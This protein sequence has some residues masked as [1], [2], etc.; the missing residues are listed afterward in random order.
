MIEMSA[1]NRDIGDRKVIFE[2][3]YYFLADIGWGIRYLHQRPP[4][5]PDYK[6]LGRRFGPSI[7]LIEATMLQQNSRIP[8]FQNFRI[9]EFQ[10]FRIPEFQNFRISE[11]R[12]PDAGLANR[13]HWIQP[14]Q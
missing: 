4:D 3:S 7:R 13:G 1:G 12:H 14:E 10:N 9:S 5:N 6:C 8:E 2:K 11:F